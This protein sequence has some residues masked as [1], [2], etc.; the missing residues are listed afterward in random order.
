MATSVSSLRSEKKFDVVGYH[1]CNHEKETT[2]SQALDITGL[3]KGKSHLNLPF[4]FVS[5]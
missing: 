2:G 4:D 1:A 5:I 3:Q